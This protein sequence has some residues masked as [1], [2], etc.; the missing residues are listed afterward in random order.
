MGSAS[1]D[2]GTDPSAGDTSSGGAPV[3][4]TTTTAT[5]TDEPGFDAV[6]SVD[7][8]DSGTGLFPGW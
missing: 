3:D 4:T 7:A 5:T 8:D 1:G 2:A 6:R